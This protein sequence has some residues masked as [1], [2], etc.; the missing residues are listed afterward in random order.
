MKKSWRIWLGVVI[1]LVFLGIAFRGQDFNAIRQALRDFNYIYLIPALALLFTGIWFRAVR[2]RILLKPVIEISSRDV[3]PIVIIG[4]MANN[5]LPLRAGELARTYALSSKTGA[6]K[7]ATLA[8]IAVERLFDGVTMLGFILISATVISLTSNLRHLAIIAFIVFTCGILFLVL[9]TLSG[10]WRD[11]IL[12]IVL[13]PLPEVMA[14]RIEQMTESFLVG[15]GVLRRRRDLALVAAYSVIA[16]SFEA[17]TYWMIAKGFG[18][19]L[20]AAMSPAAALLTTGVA[21]LATL[22]PSSPGYV[23]PFE[24]GVKWVVEGALGM[25]GSLAL[26]YAILVHATLFFPVTILG[27]FVLWRQHISLGQLREAEE[28]MKVSEVA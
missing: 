27:L 3:F 22:I 25:S 26:S 7:S 16:W 28:E 12:Q 11:R 10:N 9:L 6:K 19:P 13:G 24:T 21:N 4:F 20:A 14:D 5:I 23:G 2:W 1:T 18:D 17:S 15:L 8:T